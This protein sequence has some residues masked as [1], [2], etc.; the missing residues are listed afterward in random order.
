[1]PSNAR[2]IFSSKLAAF[3]APGAASYTAAHGVQAAGM[4]TNFQIEQVFELSNQSIYENI[5]GSPDVQVSLSKVLD[6]YCPL[7]LMATQGATAASLVARGA[8]STMFGL[9]IHDQS[10]TAATGVPLRE[11]IVSGAVVGSVSYNFPVDGNFTEDITLQG[12]NKA[13]KTGNFVLTNFTEFIND[14]PRAISGSGGVNRREDFIWTSSTLTGVAVGYDANGMINSTDISVFP[15]DIDGVS[16]SGINWLQSDGSRSAHVQNVSVS[17]DF[18]REEILE[19]GKKTYYA[20]FANP[21]IEV[22]TTIN[23]LAVQWD[24]V[25]CNDDGVL[26]NGNNTRDRTI[27]IRTREGLLVDLGIRNRMSSVEM[28][29]GDAGGGNENITYTYVNFNDLSVKHPSDLTTA[30][31]IP[32]AQ[33]TLNGV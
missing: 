21:L 9:A 25:S 5:E 12:T 10:V 11:C 27:K 29:G 32:G 14:A 16:S 31:R 33:G 13:W 15:P 6:G 28:S 24:T 23:T 17:A 20:R 3:A 4:T 19:L 7:Y 1:M 8:T 18:G 22:T 2:V 26:G 30:L